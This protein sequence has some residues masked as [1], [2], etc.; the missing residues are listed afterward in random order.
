MSKKKSIYKILHL[1]TPLIKKYQPFLS[2]HF[3]YQLTNTFHLSKNTSLNQ[4][5]VLCNL[6]VSEKCY[7]YMTLVLEK[8]QQRQYILPFF[9]FPLKAHKK[10][11][12][13][14]M[15]LGQGKTYSRYVNG[16]LMNPI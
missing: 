13:P 9:Q 11:S 16:R 3:K 12:M 4:A 2:L 6:E 10:H 1:I 14:K 8:M 7:T 15:L 5:L